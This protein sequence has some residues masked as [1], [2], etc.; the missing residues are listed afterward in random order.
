MSTGGL[1]SEEERT[2]HINL[3][4]LAGRALATKTF[5]KGRKNIHVLLRMDNTTSIAYINRMG[6]TRSQTLSQTACDLW[7][8]CLQRGITLSAVHLPGVLNSIADG[9][10]RTLQS[11]AEWMLE[12]SIC[13]GIIQILGSCSVDLFAT[14][15]NNQLRRYIS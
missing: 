8:W 12:R 14:H 10:S 9:A 15:L 2:H 3:L 4:E 7:H 6:G 5:T 13:C 1:W 11:S